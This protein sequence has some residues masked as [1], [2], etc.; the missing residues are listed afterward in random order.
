MYC[1]DESQEELRRVREAMRDMRR[2]RLHEEEMERQK[3]KKRKYRERRKKRILMSELRHRRAHELQAEQERLKKRR[4]RERKKKSI[5]CVIIEDLSRCTDSEVSKRYPTKKRIL[6]ILDFVKCRGFISAAQNVFHTDKTLIMKLLD[7]R[8]L[9]L[10]VGVIE[11]YWGTLEVT[12]CTLLAVESIMGLKVYFVDL[13]PTIQKMLI[14]GGW[15]GTLVKKLQE[16]QV[17]RDADL[18]AQ[19][20]KVLA[21]VVGRQ[22]VIGVVPELKILQVMERY[23]AHKDVTVQG[24][25]LLTH[26][27]SRSPSVYRGRICTFAASLLSMPQESQWTESATRSAIKLLSVLVKCPENCVLLRSVG[28]AEA[29]KPYD[30]FNKGINNDHRYDLGISSAST[31][32]RCLR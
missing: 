13:F 21:S 30:D 8:L 27:I 22:L 5:D 11:R 2:K 24:C 28:V 19:C 17:L 1:V 29:L 15:I 23:K 12:R 16:E 9:T 6:E 31:V 18:T 4:Y 10:L 25:S 20:M 32:L 3:F 7:H 26:I 14:S